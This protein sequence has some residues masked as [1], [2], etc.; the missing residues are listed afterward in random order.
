MGDSQSQ[1]RKARWRGDDG[2]A[3]DAA[4]RLTVAFVL[5]VLVP[6]LTG[7]LLV[8]RALPR[9]V[10]DRQQ[11]D[12]G[13]SSRLVAQVLA[14]YCDRAGDRAEA[15]GRA[16]TLPRP[17][18]ARAVA[19]SFVDRGMADGIQVSGPTGPP[20]VSVGIVPTRPD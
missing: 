1:H 9:A 10:H 2:R 20:F 13:S 11:A 5:V 4:L 17:A 14:G 6:L 18:G 19:Q 16:G 8:A 15:A 12:I 7:L 3:C